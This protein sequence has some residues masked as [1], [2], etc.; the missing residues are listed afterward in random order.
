MLT[1]KNIDMKARVGVVRACVWSVLLCSSRYWTI[2][3]EKEGA[4]GSGGVVFQR[5]SEDVKDG[6]DVQVLVLRGASL[7][8][9]LIETMRQRQL[10]FLGHVCRQGALGRLAITGGIGGKHSGGIEGITFV[11]SRGQWAKVATAAL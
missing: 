1:D 2:Y 5:N 9:S 4:K 3:M 6:E 8:R 11:E 10:Q 7:E